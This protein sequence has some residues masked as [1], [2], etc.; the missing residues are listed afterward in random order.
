MRIN[1]EFSLFVKRTT[2]KVGS[3]LRQAVVVQK[4]DEEFTFIV[5]NT[6]NADKTAGPD[7]EMLTFIDDLKAGDCVKLEL[8]D[9]TIKSI[10]KYS[11]TRRPRH[12]QDRRKL[13][14]NS[15]HNLLPSPLLFV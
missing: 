1:R 9:K 13:I 10:K 8:S 7:M 6:T 3:D 11:P 12:D 4:F 2:E 5:P 15:G 14:P